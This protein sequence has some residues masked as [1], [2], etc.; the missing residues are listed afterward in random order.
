MP[1][2]VIVGGQFGSEGKGKVAEFWARKHRADAVVRV[3]GSNSGHTTLTSQDG[4]RRVLRQL[5]TA[6][7][8]PDVLCVLAPGAYIDPDVLLREIAEVGLSPE[9]LVVDPLAMTIGADDIAAEQRSGLGARIGSTCSGT[10][11]AVTRRIARLNR[12]QLAASHPDLQPFLGQTSEVLRTLLDRGGR[13]VLEG[14]QGFGLSLLHS[15]HYP[16][17]T[18]RDTTAAAVVA[19]AGLS[20]RDVDE[21]V[22]VARAFPIR[23]A[24]DSG[25]FDAPEL[26]WGTIAAEGRHDEALSEFTS[27]T[28]R[29]RRVA[30]FDPHLVKKAIRVN[31]P[32]AV[33]VN[34]VD[35][36]DSSARG[37]LTDTAANFVAGVA[38]ELG[39]APDYVG[40]GPDCLL[41]FDLA[42]DRAVTC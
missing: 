34:H 11:A 38:A 37:L 12:D 33:I 30:R 17:V 31:Q 2:T 20:P 14:T 4:Q 41:K 6:A 27:V 10:G 40:L 42:R 18:S 13:V 15:P 25:P 7:L 26:D 19:E 29:L 24:G 28:G 23:V 5:P 8:M 9:R 16:K 39:R 36:V 21:V 1:A 35:Y 3:G 32:T 22:L